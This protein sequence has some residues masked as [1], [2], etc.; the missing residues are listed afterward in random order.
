VP[1]FDERNARAISEL[2][3]HCRGEVLTE[4]VE[5]GSYARDFGGMVQR[6]P[7][8]VLRPRSVSD[9]LTALRVATEHDLPLTPRGAG[10]SQSGQ[11]LGAGI[12]LDM[13]RLDDIAFVGTG[14]VEVG[15]GAVWRAVVDATFARAQ[16]P[17][18]LTHALDPTVAG[19]LSV[20]GVGGES[21]RVGPQVDN[22]LYFD[23]ALARGEVVRASATENRDLYDAVRSG[24][25]QCGIIVRAGYPLRACGQSVTVRSFVFT[26]A[27]GLL[28]AV[29]RIRAW[30]A[31]GTWLFAGVARDP[32]R[33]RRVFVLLVGQEEG[34]DAA[35]EPP[36]LDAQLER[37]R[38]SAPL[39]DRTGQPGHPFFQVF[40]TPPASDL[41]RTQL[42][43]WVEHI[44]PPQSATATL[45]RLLAEEEDSTSEAKFRLIFIRRCE[46]QAPLFAT[47]EGDWLTGL[48]MFASFPA[49]QRERAETAVEAHELRVGSHGSKRYLSGYLKF[50]STSDWVEHYGPAWPAFA[51]AKER[52]DPL[53]VLNPGFVHWH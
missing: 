7:G 49:N 18:G 32:R 35:A 51:R 10:H 22:V 53:H 48:G 38:R 44:L 2:R 50:A 3:R 41:G 36:Q 37:P 15:G 24:L 40:G 39:W 34:G 26:S 11:G 13:V 14:S 28:N 25:G 43:P 31:A 33:G 29:Q 4:A 5:L 52:F 23:V 42:N 27:G 8:C 17:V 6:V 9:V 20:A 45:E 21:F 1:G 19:T 30:D 12:L 16:I 46:R 47:P